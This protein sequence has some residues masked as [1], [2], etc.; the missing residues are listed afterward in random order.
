M[1][2][3]RRRVFQIFEVCL[4]STAAAILFQKPMPIISK[5]T[6]SR[7]FVLIFNKVWIFPRRKKKSRI[8][9][10]TYNWQDEG[11]IV[12]TNM[13]FFTERLRRK[14]EMQRCNGF[15]CWLRRK[16]SYPSVR[17]FRV[18]VFSI[19]SAK[20]LLGMHF[21]NRTANEKMLLQRSFW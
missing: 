18:C 4:F 2:A 1:A 3:W 7:V 15:E 8:Y 13:D 9:Y 5:L 14:T 20:Y 19:Q 21:G 12:T 10:C 17:F 11:A 16:H 6:S